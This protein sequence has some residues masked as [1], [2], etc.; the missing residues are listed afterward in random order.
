MGK[1]RE[2]E[3]EWCGKGK[4]GRGIGE[5]RGMGGKEEEVMGLRVL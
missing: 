1:G 5:E 3:R 4:R 2:G